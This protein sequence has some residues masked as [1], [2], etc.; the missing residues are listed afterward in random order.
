[1]LVFLLLPTSIQSGWLKN[2]AYM[3]MGYEKEPKCPEIPAK[4]PSSGFDVWMFLASMALT[5]NIAANIVNNVNNN[6]NNDNEDNQNTF[7]FNSYMNE[8]SNMNM[9]MLM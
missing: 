7:N 4:K 6:N 2:V 3:P 8:N 1:M 9:N 5:S